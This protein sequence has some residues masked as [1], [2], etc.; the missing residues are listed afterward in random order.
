MFRASFKGLKTNPIPA[1]LAWPDEALAYFVR[2]DLLDEALPRQETLWDLPEAVRLL[3]KQQADGS[4]NYPGQ[5]NTPRQNY[6][7][8]Q[9]YRCLRLLV[10]V[11]GLTAEHPAL[12]KA[13]AYLF[14]CQTPQG[15]IRG[16]LG[17]QTM[18]YYHGA[19]LELLVKAGLGY[20]PHVRCGLDWLLSVRQA[21]GGWIVPAQAIPSRQRSDEFWS[22]PAV[23]PDRS[24][25]HAHLA[26][27]MALR[28]FAAHPAY[29]H[30]SQVIAAARA[31]KRRFFQAD[32]YNDRKAPSYWFK[33]QFPFWWAN[34]L[35]ALDSLARLGF[36]CRDPDVAR[37]LQWFVDNQ[38]SD[39]LWP[40]GYGSGR[41]AE[42]NRRW[43][44]LA[45]CRVFIQIYEE[46]R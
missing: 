33:F 44:G 7:L 28:A 6:A 37:G 20:D 19:I 15:D 46:Y 38:A 8:L 23:P 13:A 39:G 25:P 5:S 42:D 45:V 29:R 21:D 18:P 27:G 31:L 1:L 26:T 24:L 4:W 2:R 12:Q 17:N 14:S 35:T 16:I 3:A 30:H 9:T 36:D 32:K 41:K 22:G 11:Y 40:T 10:E 43:V 34:L